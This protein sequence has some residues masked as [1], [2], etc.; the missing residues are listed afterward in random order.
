MFVNAVDDDSAG[1]G[2]E[3]VP[4]DSAAHKGEWYVFQKGA[5]IGYSHVGYS[6]TVNGA[7]VTGALS[8]LD[9]GA[10]VVGVRLYRPE[11]GREAVADAAAIARSVAT[12]LPA[13][14]VPTTS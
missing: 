2:G 10:T 9:T 6:S 1:S 3:Q 7:K 14:P 13:A 5:G 8:F 12:A 11:P 4:A